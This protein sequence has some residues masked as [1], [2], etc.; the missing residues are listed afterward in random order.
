VLYG[1]WYKP[2][3]ACRADGPDAG[4]LPAVSHRD[5][6][7]SLVCINE[8][9]VPAE[10]VPPWLNPTLFILLGSAPVF[11]VSALVIQARS[12]LRRDVPPIR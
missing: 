11:Y 2:S 7:I 10:R 12:Q 4:A 6:P 9:G 3:E 8:N 1:V 5:F